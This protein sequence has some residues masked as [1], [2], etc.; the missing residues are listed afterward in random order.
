MQEV[1]QN[2]KSYCKWVL[3]TAGD[4]MTACSDGMKALAMYIHEMELE[5]TYVRDDF[6]TIPSARGAPESDSGMEEDSY[7]EDL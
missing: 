6:V 3:D 4:D 7:H 2:D 1:W 5:E